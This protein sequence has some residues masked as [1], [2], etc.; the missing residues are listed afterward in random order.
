VTRRFRPR[1]ITPGTA[2]A[3]FATAVYIGYF[4]AAGG[5]LVLVVLGSIIARPLVEVNAAKT[6]LSGVTNAVAAIAFALFGPV[7]WELVAPLAIGLFVGGLTGP[8]LARRIPSTVLRIMI[9]GCGL[10]VAGVLAW[11]TY[12]G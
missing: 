1:G 9:A 11:A 2:A 10:A 7:R 12:V 5:I 4:G 3:Y 6:V 8:W